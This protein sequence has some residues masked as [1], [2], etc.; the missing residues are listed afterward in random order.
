MLSILVAGA[1]QSAMVIT[2]PHVLVFSR[3][4]GFRHDSIPNAI[5][6][7]KKMGTD[8]GFQVDATEDPSVFNDANLKQY[9]L[10]AFA[11]TTGTILDADQKKAMERFVE[12]GKGWI[13]IHSAA[14]T[15]YDWPW[16]GELVGA[17][18]KSH[19]PG[20]QHV[21][22]QIENRGN[23]STTGLPS[24]WIRPDE[25][26]DWRVNPRSKVQVLASLD[27]SFYR[28]G[29][30][31]DHPIMW[32]HW[33][34]K[35]RSW[36][37]EMGHTK[38]SY[39]E[40][41]YVDQLYGGLMWAAQGSR[42]PDGAVDFINSNKGY[43]DCFFHAEFMVQ[44]G[45]H[46]QI[47]FG[48]KNYIAISD[49]SNVAWDKLS[50]VDCGGI[51]E[52]PPIVNAFAGAT[53]WNTLDVIFRPSLGS[54]KEVRLNGIVVQTNVPFHGPGGAFSLG[55]NHATFRNVWVKRLSK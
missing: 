55:T 22:V 3:T 31:Q 26:Y 4:T 35:G 11:S 34:G 53:Y 39:T 14:D 9:D 13:G 25:W 17:W 21:K 38:E 36:Y 45:A 28:P 5:E 51:N 47:G 50:G 20:G 15:E 1:M 12:S 24:L 19:P 43:G 40:K 18:F 44:A 37:T 8:H 23:P 16:Y 49:S 30:P 52:N 42:R 7:I 10:I 29:N 32:C 41:P 33:Q 46:T 27:E 48:S 6:A 54:I 2:A